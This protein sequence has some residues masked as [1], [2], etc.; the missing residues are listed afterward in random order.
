MDIICRAKTLT[1]D[2][3]VGYYIKI[4]DI[5]YIIPENSS[6]LNL[7]QI[8]KSTLDRFTGKCDHN[9]MRVFINDCVVAGKYFS[10]CINFNERDKEDYTPKYEVYYKYIGILRVIDNDY[11]IGVERFNDLISDDDSFIDGCDESFSDLVEEYF[12]ENLGNADENI[13]NIYSFWYTHK[14][15]MFH[16]IND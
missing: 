10:K 15:K 4:N 1:N 8:D 11:Y 3:I 13:E 5:D 9:N 2:W 12:I 14:D 6:N 7:I 16:D